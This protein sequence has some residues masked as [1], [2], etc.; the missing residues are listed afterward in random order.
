MESTQI[1]VEPQI[2]PK[3]KLLRIL[4]VTFGLAIVIGGIIGVGILRTPGMVAANLGLTWLIIAVWIFGGI[5]TLI[6][7]NTYA[8]LGTMLPEA[9]GPYVYAKKTYGV[10]G[11]FLIGWSDWFLN[12]CATAYLAVAAGEYSALLFPTLDGFVPFVAVAVLIFFGGLH[13]LGLRVGSGAQKVTSLLKV[14]AFLVLI[15]ACFVFGGEP[16]LLEARQ[17]AQIS[18]ST[19]IISF[20]A[21]ILSLQA[22]IETY[23]GWNSVV[24]FSEENTDP[25]RN[26]PRALFGGVLLVMVIYLLFNL[27]LLYALPTSQIAASNLPAADAAASIFGGM[28]GKIITALALASLLGIINAIVL[29]TPRTLFAMSRDGLFST[30]GAMVNDGGTPTVGLVLTILLAVILAASGTFESLL[31]IAA[32]MGLTVDVSVY[33]ALFIL[34][35][36]EPELPRPFKAR[37]YPFLPLIVLAVSILLLIGYI[38]GNTMNSVF[39]LVA[40]ALSYPAYLIV[41]RKVDA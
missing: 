15:V 12:T 34:R 30:K 31:A 19:S 17:A 13:W 3:D 1:I 6:G 35:K 29:Q 22:V 8:E 27:A 33:V 37:G 9:G 18:T 23:A 39:A 2:A 20:V 26:I 24:Y 32:F 14:L 4:G 25:A 38:I 16:S 7:A 11:G 21:V 28:G 10:F 36:R 40:M 5:Y 41:R